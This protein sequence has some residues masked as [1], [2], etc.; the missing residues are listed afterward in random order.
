MCRKKV[1]LFILAL[2][3]SLSGCAWWKRAD[4]TKA[5]PEALYQQGYNHYGKG[6]YDK[7]IKLFQRVKEEYPLSQVALLAEIGIAD[8][9]FSQGEYTEAEMAYNDFINLHP[10]NE[11]LPYTMYQLGMCHYKQMSSIDRDQTETLKARKEFE[12]LNS[13]FPGSKFSFLTEKKLRDCKKR[14]GEHEFYVG[15]FYF[16]TK[17]YKAALRRFETI[18]RDYA[19]LGLDYKVSYFIRETRKHL[20]EEEAPKKLPETTPPPEGPRSLW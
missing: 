19:N 3:L 20:A 5:T 11:N 10:T 14:L 9:H 4:M 6:R 18:T 12:R 13:R 16:K 7:A 17:R 15:Y 2:L 1:F 8:S